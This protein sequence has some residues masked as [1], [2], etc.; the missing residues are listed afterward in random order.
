[1][2]K[3]EVDIFWEPTGG[4]INFEYET[5]DN[6]EEEDVCNEIANQLLIVPWLIKKDNNKDGD[7]SFGA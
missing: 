5:D 2:A 4:N 3:W 1:M 7:S 6:I